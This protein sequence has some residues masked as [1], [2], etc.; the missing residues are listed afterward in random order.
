MTDDELRDALE[1]LYAYDSGSVSSGIRDETLR[2]R[3]IA[4]LQA[5]TGP[6]E[7]FPR[8]LIGRMVRDLWLSEEALA[9]GYG[10]EEAREFINWL[11]DRMR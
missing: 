7:L 2:A 3:C 5:R 4:E 10:P 6:Y 11:D 8:V 9:E 1:G